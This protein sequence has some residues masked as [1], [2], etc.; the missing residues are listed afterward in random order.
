MKPTIHELEEILSQEDS[1]QEIRIQPDGSIKVIDCTGLIQELADALKYP[2]DIDS[3]TVIVT[4]G[5]IR[6]TSM[7]IR[8]LEGRI[9]K[10]LL[11]TGE[12]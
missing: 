11:E 9:K 10:A 4:Q 2:A 8:Y 3:C 12:T 5:L 6:R 1:D 7:R